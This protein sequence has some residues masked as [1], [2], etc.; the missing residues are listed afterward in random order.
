MSQTFSKSDVAAHNKPDDLYIIVDEDVYDLTTFADEHPGGKKILQRVAGKDASKQFWKYHNESILK[1]YQKKLQVG[2]LDSKPKPEAPPTP[3]QE[4]VQPVAESGT[5]SATPGPA[6][7]QVQEESV[8]FDEFGDL[9]PYAD[10]SWYQTV[11]TTGGPRENA[12]LTF[13]QYHSPYYNETHVAL[14]AEV[15]K[16]VEDEVMPNTTE[17]DEA[18]MVPE[19]IY[20]QM[21]ERGY[22]AG[23]LGVEFPADITNKRVKCVPPEKWDRFHELII[24]DELSRCGSGGVVWNLIGGF[25]IGCPPLVQFGKPELVKRVLPRILNGDER[26]C[27]A[28]TEPGKPFQINANLLY[29]TVS[30]CWK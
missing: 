2:S 3:P 9:V 26:I 7:H 16:W 1:K 11:R 8:A 22:L 28:V 5:L 24:T 14:R 27:L 19:S 23:L 21:G 25:G 15:R 29:L 30:R 4:V 17:W 13:K 6:A 20:K 10:P 12:L 18:R